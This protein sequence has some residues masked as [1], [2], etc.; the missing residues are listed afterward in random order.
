MPGEVW[1]SEYLRKPWDFV[2]PPIPTIFLLVFPFSG[3][4][5]L[6]AIF[7]SLS[8]T[9]GFVF[10]H[11]IATMKAAVSIFQPTGLLLL[12]NDFIS[13]CVCGLLQPV[14][15]YAYKGGFAAAG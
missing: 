15:K 13:A 11:E 7:T 3:Q 5:T 8:F 9:L 10:E 12:C 14:T 6:V 4:F 1:Q 2:V